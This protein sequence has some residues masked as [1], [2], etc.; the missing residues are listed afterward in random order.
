VLTITYGPI[1]SSD[2]V[3]EMYAITDTAALERLKPA[4]AKRKRDFDRFISKLPKGKPY[5]TISKAE[6]KWIVPVALNNA[7]VANAVMKVF[8]REK[9]A[10]MG[11]DPERYAKIAYNELYMSVLTARRAVSIPP[12]F[13]RPYTTLLGFGIGTLPREMQ[14]CAVQTG[15]DA[16]CIFLFSE[17]MD[18]TLED[19]LRDTSTDVAVSLV[20]ELLALLSQERKLFEF[21]HGD[22][23]VKNVFI[24]KVQPGRRRIYRRDHTDA[25]SEMIIFHGDLMPVFGDFEF[26]S[27]AG[28]ETYVRRQMTDLETFKYDLNAVD[29]KSSSVFEVMR[30]MGRIMNVY[31]A[32]PRAR[33]SYLQWQYPMDIAFEI[34]KEFPNNINTIQ[35]AQPFRPRCEACLLPANSMCGNQCGTF[36]C[37]EQCASADW[38]AHVATTKCRHH[39]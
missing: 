32:P 15:P 25:T 9:T 20:C 17:K 37:S 26:S 16:E 4:D 28:D 24:R 23:T 11:D 12:P 6:C 29:Q 36:Y 21:Q 10:D 19:V 34:M 7:N 18:G 22:L 33:D 13:P 3:C 5:A 39:Q 31:L 2:D 14:A 1:L 30:V 38:A 27:V 8:L 35:T